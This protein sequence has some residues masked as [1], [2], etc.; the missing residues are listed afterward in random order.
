MRSVNKQDAERISADSTDTAWRTSSRCSHGDCVQV[1]SFPAR[2]VAVRDTKNR[3][4]GPDLVF[5]PAAW[6][7]FIAGVREDGTAR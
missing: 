6:R 7:S 4:G 3:G 1:G 2:A 5:A